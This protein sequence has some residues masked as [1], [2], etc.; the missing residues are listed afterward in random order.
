MCSN[1][2][3][4][5]LATI[6]LV[7]AG[8]CAPQTSVVKLYEDSAR[9]TKT[10]KRLLIVDI[11]SDRSQQQRFE[12]E[13]ASKLRQD[14]VDA[15]PIHAKLDTSK[16]VSQGDIN[17]ISD[18]IG[19]DAILITHIASV[20]TKMDV[21]EGREEI[22]STCRGGDPVDYFLYDHDIIVE[23]DSVKVAHTVVVISNLYDG[24]NHERVWSIQSTCFGKDSLSEVMG[25]EADAIARRLRIDEL[26]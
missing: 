7:L 9:A 15:T 10:Y 19:A 17:R 23:P 8:A 1:V 24:R 22:K 11:S 12:D 6:A 5:G 13:L 18:E 16:G 21:V 26:I 25:K 20:D 2:R 14:Q 4:V 3:M